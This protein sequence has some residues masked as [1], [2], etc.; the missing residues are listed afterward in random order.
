MTKKSRPVKHY[1]G[2]LARLT[3][4]IENRA[5]DIARLLLGDVP[6]AEQKAETKKPVGRMP[7]RRP[8]N[9]RPSTRKP[10]KKRNIQREQAI[11]N[12]RHKAF[13]H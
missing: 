2:E 1:P 9:T 8:G 12:W 5:K 11:S 10:D 7:K 6:D 3:V 4:L 13:R